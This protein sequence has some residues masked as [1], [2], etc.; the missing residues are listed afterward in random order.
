EDPAVVS[1]ARAATMRALKGGGA[2]DPTLANVVIGTAARHGDAALFDA[3]VAAAER[4]TA[5]EE[6]DRYLFPL[7][8]FR[9]SALVDRGLD[10]RLSPQL[11]SEDTAI[12]LAPFFANPYA[13]DGAW[14]FV[15]S[16]W[17]AL[18]PKVTIFGGDTSLTRSL[19]AFCD[20]G[21]RD[22]I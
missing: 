3:L 8:Y 4:P 17:Q 10:L 1:Q 6:H 15:K 21:A 14:A 7:G 13:R 16:R 22:D 9:D 19:S 18:E 12:Y 20:A 5:P 11:R 2:L